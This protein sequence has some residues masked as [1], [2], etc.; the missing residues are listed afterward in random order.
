[1]DPA[2]E[3][4]ASMMV[5]VGFDMPDL[6]AGRER[7][8]VL[9]LVDVLSFSTAV[10]A[11]T[12][13]GA[14]ILP[15]GSRRRAASMALARGAV[16]SVPRREAGPG[17][18]S[19]SPLSFQHATAGTRVVLRSPNGARMAVAALGAPAVV[20]AGIVNATACGASA[21]AGARAQRRGVTVIACGERIGPSRR[22]RFAAEDFL[23]AGA[24]AAAVDLPRTGEAETAIRAF[25]SC[26]ADLER[27]LLQ[28][29]SGI[30]LV[31]AGFRDDVGFASRLDSLSVVP[32]LRDGELRGR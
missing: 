17:Q 26:R 24:V 16:A 25:E 21:G 28:T 9:V 14:I 8:D 27:V 1:M 19:L 6:R 13:R 5:H 4:P 29:R 20:V 22:R 23:G 18:Y 3:G 11:G 32:L 15:A 12:S 2:P 7:G 30:E 10:A 31:G